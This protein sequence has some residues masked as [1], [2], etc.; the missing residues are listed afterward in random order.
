[1]DGKAGGQARRE[2]ASQTPYNTGVVAADLWAAR[3]RRTAT[4]LQL[5][6]ACR[7]VRPQYLGA[8]AEDIF[9]YHRDLLHELVA[10]RR[11]RV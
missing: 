3:T 9:H 10:A 2:R 1:M 6:V 7:G 11:A 5:P 8:N 4:P